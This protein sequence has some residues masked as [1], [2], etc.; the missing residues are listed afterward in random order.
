MPHCVSMQ[1]STPSPLLALVGATAEWHA[2]TPPSCSA[3]VRVLDR[4]HFTVHRGD[5]VVVH[6]DDPASA[7]V[8]LAALAGSPALLGGRRMSGA[9]LAAPTVRIRRCSVTADALDAVLDGWRDLRP[10]AAAMPS[11]SGGAPGVAV[12]LLRASRRAPLATREYEQ[13]RAWARRVRLE[14]GAVVAVATPQPVGALETAM[15]PAS[16]PSKAAWTW[17]TRA[18]RHSSQ[19]QQ[20]RVHEHPIHEAPPP[21]QMLSAAAPRGVWLRHGQLFNLRA[22]E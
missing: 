5:C 17:P 15:G 2:G 3:R 1:S 19:H 11:T 9:R 13:W 8:L 18:G 4:V 7:R 10:D 20:G 6:H 16:S 21:E 12:H 22:W 14:G